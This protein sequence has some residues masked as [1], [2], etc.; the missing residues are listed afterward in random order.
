MQAVGHGDMSKVRCWFAG[1]EGDSA[2]PASLQAQSAAYLIPRAIEEEFDVS[3]FLEGCKGAFVAGACQPGWSRTCFHVVKRLLWL[4]TQ[5]CCS[6]WMLWRGLCY[7]SELTV[8]PLHSRCFLP[9]LQ[10]T[11]ACTAQETW[12]QWCRFQCSTPLRK[13]NTFCSWSPQQMGAHGLAA[14]SQLTC[15]G[16]CLQEC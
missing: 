5:A 14:C 12:P 3:Q 4:V 6:A 13:C 16:T 9:V 8:H 2:F 10:C 1:P 15:T 7:L 11:R